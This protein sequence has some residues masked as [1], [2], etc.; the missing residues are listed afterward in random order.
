MQ[1]ENRNFTI[2]YHEKYDVIVTG[3]G[4][5]GCTAAAAAAREGAK[6][7]LL[8]SS[9]CLGGMGTSGLSQFG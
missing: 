6:V 5:A 2:S 9:G 8:E 7:L 4:P 1:Q 3:G